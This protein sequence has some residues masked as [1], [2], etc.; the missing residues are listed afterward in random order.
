MDH[1]LRAERLNNSESSAIFALATKINS[2][3]AR[4]K[5]IISLAA[6][7]ADFSTPQYICQAANDAIASGFTKYTSISGITELKQAIKHKFLADN[8]L[9]YDLDQILVANGAKQII[10]NAMF[11]TVNAGEQVV[12]PAPY[13]ASYP[14]MVSIVGGQPVFIKTVADNGYKITAKQLENA[15][16]DK[17]KLVILN[18]PS[19]PT[20]MVYSY[21]ELWSLAQV[22]LRYPNVLVI[23]DDI[24]EKILY[25]NNT[26]HTIASVE[27][28]LKN[29]VLTIN[30]VSKAYAMT[31]WRIGY[32]AGPTWLI[33]AMHTIQSQSTS[34]ACSIAQ[35][36]AYIAL[37]DLE[38]SV[39]PQWI[40]EFQ[41]RRDYVVSRLN[42]IAGIKCKLPDGAFY[43]F[44]SCLALLGKKTIDGQI[45]KN[46]SDFCN[47]LLSHAGVA[48]V[49]GSAFGYQGHFRL[50]FV[51]DMPSLQLA[52]DK[53]A[54]TLALLK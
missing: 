45:I 25:D 17:T 19:N 10:F 21:E 35:K 43:V 42:N 3:K 4:G 1:N 49:P 36:A 33:K 18:S 28:Q 32:G 44:P 41:I 40:K 54:G 16:T 48:V 37:I 31:G 9:E 13:W 38:Q 47:Y 5:K 29:R 6:G 30:G 24:Y 51:V 2:L 20:G 27:P 23:S 7:E 53:I 50:S 46:D 34:G 14:S 52:T 15:M 39:I 22:L 11:A 12:I 8:D 26:F